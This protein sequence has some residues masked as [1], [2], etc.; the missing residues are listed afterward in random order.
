MSF[1]SRR[2][3]RPDQ[4][5]DRSG[6]GR[7]ADSDYGDY[8][9]APDDYQQDDDSWS[10]DE[11]FSPEG[12][13]G[14]WAAGSRP[15]SRGRGDDHGYAEYGPGSQRGQ[16]P[17]GQSGGYGRDAYQQDSY[18]Q[19]DGYGDEYGTGGEYAT[20]GYETID[21]PDGDRDERGGRK[22]RADRGERRRRLRRDKGDDIW[23][24][25]GVSDEDYWASV[26]ADRPLNSTGS[27]LDAE[28]MNVVNSRP[29][30]RPSGTAHPARGSW[31]A[32]DRPMAAEPRFAGEP[33]T[34]SGRLGPAPGTLGAPVA[35]GYVPGTQGP[36]SRQAVPGGTAAR[37]GA[38]S[39]P[40]GRLGGGPGSGPMPRAG[41][42][43]S[44]PM[45]RQG[46]GPNSG[47]MP[48]AAMGPG[49][50]PMP[51]AAMNP[52]SGP[53]PRAAGANSGP[54]ARQGTGPTPAW[55][56]GG[57]GAT[58]SHPARSGTGPSARSGAGPSPARGR[59][60]L[61]ARPAAGLAQPGLS[62]PGHSQPTVAQPALM[63]S[64]QPN[65]GRGPSRQPEP[66]PEW[67][68]RTERIDRVAASGH[69][70]PRVAG[71]GKA[72]HAP[73][74]ASA[75]ASVWGQDGS[76]TLPEPARTGGTGGHLAA[77][78]NSEDDPLTSKRYSREELSR[79]D[80]RSYRG[81]TRRAQVTA[82]QYAAALT[83]QTQT[84]SLNGQYQADPQA[85]TG[86]Y[87]AQGGQR[88]AQPT[89]HANPYDRGTAPASYPYPGQPYPSGPAADQDAE[90]YYRPARQVSPDAGRG[91]NGGYNT[92]AGYNG[93]GGH[94]NGYGNGRY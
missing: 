54:M 92:G 29:M 11:Y 82:E 39:G 79:T 34:G 74:A 18:G 28:P 76:P 46:G 84:F 49:S 70:D 77:R 85:V 71:R 13:K 2:T 22:R 43:S 26:A 56:A 10:P 30:A 3:S 57:S 69:P 51:R 50:G 83:E 15:G 37:A 86:R 21:G 94:G 36:V 14:R 48:R 93:N 40:M 6:A 60:A 55:P 32:A 47:P 4:R 16:A 12:I 58:G 35:P 75:P 73:A 66:R 41:G 81:A 9:Y 19:D 53:M 67:G 72:P 64:F 42:A 8:D 62:Q 89:Q 25:D 1:L 61:P 44:G 68:E 33:R 38:T 24:D 87:P 80:G 27:P 91:G 59:E 7:Q 23:P 90:R 31:P 65:T 88:P 5:G 20:G 17:R 78:R 45:A 63:P 52:N